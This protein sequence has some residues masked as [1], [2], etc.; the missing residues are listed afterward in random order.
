[1]E[2]LQTLEM[3]ELLD[4]LAEHTTRYTQMM[5][6][7]TTKE[8]YESCK[9]LISAIQEEILRRKQSFEENT[10]ISGEPPEFE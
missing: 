7:G 9:T 3:S 4:M 2:N 5:S 6:D 1:M 8:E 10:S